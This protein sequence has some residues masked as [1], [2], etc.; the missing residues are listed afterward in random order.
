MDLFAFSQATIVYSL[1]GTNH[2]LIQLES[3]NGS[4]RQC[5]YVDTVFINTPDSIS[6]L[7][8]ITNPFTADDAYP[9]TNLCCTPFSFI[10][11][12]NSNSYVL[13][14]GANNIILNY[15]RQFKFFHHCNGN[16][17]GFVGS[18]I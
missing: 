5:K 16:V 13:D 11:D 1:P 3:S 4:F 6:A 10:A 17:K 2:A 15:S 8:N 12:T 14:T 9:D 7:D 18:N